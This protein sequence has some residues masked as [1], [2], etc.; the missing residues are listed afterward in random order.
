MTQIPPPKFHPDMAQLLLAGKKH[1]T[2]R[3]KKLGE[4]GDTFELKG[5]TFQ[6]ATVR[7]E[8]FA[9]IMYDFYRCE[10]FFSPVD[11]QMFWIRIHRGHL[12]EPGTLKWLH[13]LECLGRR[14]Q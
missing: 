14:G 12:P 2:T 1:C 8:K 13:I 4:P 10:G 11:F 5:Q 9:V 7:E 6:I 3:S